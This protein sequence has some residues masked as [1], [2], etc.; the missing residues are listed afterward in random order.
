V[1]RSRRIADVGSGREV[2]TLVLEDAVKNEKL[3]A[4]R[5]IV[6]GETTASGIA[7][8]GCR[9]GLLAADAKQ[10]APVDALGRAWHPI[11]A[12]RVDKRT[13]RKVFVDQHCHSSDLPPSMTISEPNM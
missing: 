11:D 8:D 7:D 6:M 10:H 4:A 3:F 2:A 1:A 5:M 9:A 12:I 13:P